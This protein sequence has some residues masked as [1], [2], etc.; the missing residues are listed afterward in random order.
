MDGFERRAEVEAARRGGEPGRAGRKPPPSAR[1][2]SP[3]LPETTTMTRPA[4]DPRRTTWPERAFVLAGLAGALAVT[5]A[6]FAAGTDIGHLAPLWLGAFAWTVL[7]SLGMALRRGV[8]GDWSAFRGVELSDGRD[9]RVD[10]ASKTGAYA[11]LRIAE[12]H[13]ELTRDDEPW[14]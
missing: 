14:R 11:Y 6:A 3:D 5:T 2:P 7:A 12:E 1:L 9:D 8:R 13:E 4:P 10:W